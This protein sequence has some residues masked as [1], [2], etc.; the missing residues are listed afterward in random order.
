VAGAAVGGSISSAHPRH[1]QTG[2]PLV[3]LTYVGPVIMSFGCFAL[4]FAFVVFCEARDHAVRFYM[5]SRR[6]SESKRGPR[7]CR[8]P[9][10]RNVLDLIVA[11]ARRR[12]RKRARRSTPVTSTAPD[13][14]PGEER[15]SANA[16]DDDGDCIKIDCQ[17]TPIP[18]SVGVDKATE[19]LLSNGMLHTS[20]P[21]SVAHAEDVQQNEQPLDNRYAERLLR[22][23]MPSIES[24]CD[25][26]ST[27][28]RYPSVTGSDHLDLGQDRSSVPSL[29][30]GM[31]R[32]P[33]TERARGHS[34]GDDG[35][36]AANVILDETVTQDAVLRDE[37]MP[38]MT[39]SDSPSEEDTSPESIEPETESVIND[40]VASMSL[41]SSSA[42]VSSSSSLFEV[43]VSSEVVVDDEMAMET[44]S[45]NEQKVND[46]IAAAKPPSVPSES[47]QD[48]VGSTP[49]ESPD[50][51]DR[52]GPKADVND[53]EVDGGRQ[54]TRLAP[55]PSA[56]RKAASPTSPA[57]AERATSGGWKRGDGRET[58]TRSHAGLH[59]PPPLPPPPIQPSIVTASARPPRTHK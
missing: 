56:D 48:S 18:T 42:S 27:G 15:A 44:P 35:D 36:R 46:R 53:D 58:L 41:S 1:Q 47:A 12:A 13:S 21:S 7:H 3:S 52:S 59:C 11:A 43:C 54:P 38:L 31:L 37:A 51:D 19:W 33:S 22:N 25:R 10:R 39:T 55:I 24:L 5:R 40:K 8:L 29:S 26:A 34:A 16:A 9:F 57:A 50:P 2:S 49:S 17:P 45:S 20:P 30:N 4:I 28:G 23:G 32:E 6:Y 14:N